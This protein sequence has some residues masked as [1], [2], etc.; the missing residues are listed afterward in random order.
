M[1]YICLRIDLVMDTN[2][3]NG[4]KLL[5]IS[6][7]CASV[8][9]PSWLKGGYVFESASGNLKIELETLKDGMMTI[10]FRSR[11]V[12]ASDETRENFYL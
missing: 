10:K 1:N 3:E 4:I 11:D 8:L 2:E 9:T 12:K 7:S 5:D 6:D